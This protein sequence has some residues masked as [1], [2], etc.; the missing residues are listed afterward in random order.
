MR[1]KCRSDGS[2][3]ADRFSELVDE[4]QVFSIVEGDINLFPGHLD[5]PQ[6]TRSLGGDTMARVLIQL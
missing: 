6:S 3:C 5:E 4:G 2:K 1:Y